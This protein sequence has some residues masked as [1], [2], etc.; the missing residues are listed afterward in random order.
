MGAT[1]TDAA[2]IG[3]RRVRRPKDKEKLLTRL[4]D[5]KVFD[6]YRDALVFAAA[7]GYARNSHLSFE[8]SSEP[9]PWSVFS[10]AG[11]EAL[12]N[13]ISVM[14]AQDFEILSAERFDER[15]R[16]FEE[17]ANGGL[18]ILEEI[19]ARAE[20]QSLDIVLELV[21]ESEGPR[22]TAGELAIEKFASDLAW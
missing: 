5:E 17:F 1:L 16:L 18:Q 22:E 15:L 10:G 9:I 3:T 21:M 11:Y 14:K 12:I 7:L 8:Q 4:V 2:K 20:R 6:T 19:L 13:L